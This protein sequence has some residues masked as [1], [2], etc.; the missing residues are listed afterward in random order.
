MPSMGGSCHAQASGNSSNPRAFAHWR[1]GGF[2]RP[3][4]PLCYPAVST[5]G[6]LRTLPRRC[7]SL[8]PCHWTSFC[9]RLRGGIRVLD[10]ETLLS[11]ISNAV[12]EEIRIRTAEGYQA[13]RH[14]GVEVGRRSVRRTPR[15]RVAYPGRAAGRMRVLNGPRF[16]LS[17]RDETDWRSCC[18]LP[19]AILHWRVW[20]R[21]ATIVPTRARKSASPRPMCSYSIASSR[22]LGRLPW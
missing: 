5:T 8:R 18:W 10:G 19:A 6:A 22:C 15:W 14:G 11:N 7:P 16:V 3:S 20:S 12:M 21:P 9:R 17:R 1:S 4:S 13:L 2:R